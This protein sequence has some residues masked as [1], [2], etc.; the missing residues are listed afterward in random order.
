VISRFVKHGDV[1]LPERGVLPIDRP[2]TSGQ[3]PA[4]AKE[5]AELTR[6]GYLRRIVRG[7]YVAAQV[8]D[9]LG[10]RARALRLVVP[11]AAVVTDRTAAWL[12][13]IDVLMPGE[14]VSVPPVRVFHR[15]RGGRLRRAEVSSGQR[16]MPDTDVEVV[17]GVRV[18][19][20]LRT[21]CD[22]GMHRNQD[23]AF[24]S[25]EAMVRAGV[26][27]DG[28]L[29]EIPRFRGYRWVRQFRD[30]A[31]FLD[32]RPHSIAESI[33]RLRWIRTATPWPEPQR[34]V[35]GP[36]GAEWSLDMGVEALYFAVE[37][38]GKEFHEGD[39]AIEHDRARRAWISENTPWLVRVVP[40]ENIFGKAQDFD[41]LLPRWIAEARRTLPNRL[42]RG[43]WYDEVGD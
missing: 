20:P 25:L 28:I 1:F 40:Q 43:R 26:D 42:T 12:R 38:D 11:P 5:L 17:D 7:V 9:T 37:Y 27:K 19:T 4:S 33:T 24:G 6:A 36:H 18:T 29:A 3:V 2:F 21:A 22:L 8:R 23:R 35:R 39:E 14:H 34:P 31:P 10:V 41:L 15:S 13:G 32:P 16:M 30:L